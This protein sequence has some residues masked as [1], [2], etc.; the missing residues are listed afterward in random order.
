MYITLDSAIGKFV[1][2]ENKYSKGLELEFELKDY[3]EYGLTIHYWSLGY[4]KKA[5]ELIEEM[6]KDDPYNRDLCAVKILVLGNG[7]R[8]HALLWHLNKFPST[9]EDQSLYVWPGNAGTHSLAT[10]LEDIDN[11]EQVLE[12]VAKNQIDWTLVGPEK[13]LAAGIVDEFSK[14]GFKIFGPNKKASELESSKIFAKKR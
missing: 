4:L 9:H 13:Y 6:I 5:H 7:G 10:N 3:Y 8:E 14:R 11:E 12:F 1:E 2:A